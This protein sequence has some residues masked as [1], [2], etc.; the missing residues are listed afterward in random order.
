MD[1]MDYKQHLAKLC[2]E[3][4]GSDTQAAVLFML[5]RHPEL[6]NRSPGCVALTEAGS[7]EVEGIIRRGL[8]G[9][10]V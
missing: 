8:H 6:Q 5:R 2:S 9:L 3:V 10:P 7:K 4:F 1:K